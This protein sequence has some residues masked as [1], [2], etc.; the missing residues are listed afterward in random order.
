MVE[1][2]SVLGAEHGFDD[3]IR[4]L[5]DR[6]GLTV[7]NAALADGAGPTLERTG[8]GAWALVFRRPFPGGGVAAAVP[9]GAL[10]DTF[11]LA[12]PEPG[13]RI[14]VT[15]IDGTLVL[16]APY[17]ENWV[18]ERFDPSRQ[19]AEMLRHRRSGT[20]TVAFDRADGSSHLIAYD[21]VRNAPFRVT[22]M[23]PWRTVLAGW[24][25]TAVDAA[26]AGAVGGVVVP[27]TL[28]MLFLWMRRV[29]AAEEARRAAEAANH[30]KSD[31]LAL[32]SHELR[33]PLNSVLGF[34]EM[35]RD[36]AWGPNAVDRYVDYA[37][38][39]HA[40]GS[41]LLSLLNDVLDLAKIEAGRMTLAPEPL[42]PA[43]LADACLRL[44]AGQARAS[45]VSL[46]AA[47]APGTGPL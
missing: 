26:L 34:A 35:I 47:V 28:V 18:G 15:L 23:R 21:T 14:G 39:I 1:K 16:Q 11:T 29:Q 32:M 10:A 36:R 20:A 30:A 43:V 27:T 33:T 5:I 12:T 41:H 4:Q 31:F 3:V 2:A 44:A 38:D 46:D 8:S 6:Y 9:T 19:I 42:D 24:R 37:A 13:G 17:A 7:E 45:G 25:R 22:L 40:A